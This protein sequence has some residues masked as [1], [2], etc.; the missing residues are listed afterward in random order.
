MTNPTDQSIIAA[1]LRMPLLTIS[2]SLFVVRPF[3]LTT[4]PSTVASLG[5]LL[6]LLNSGP[7]ALMDG[8]LLHSQMSTSNPS[9]KAATRATNV[10]T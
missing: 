7:H 9:A 10:G 6:V 2:Q 3:V 4:V 8:T 1:L 5:L